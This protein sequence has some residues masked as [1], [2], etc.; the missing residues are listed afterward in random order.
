MDSDGPLG[1]GEVVAESAGATGPVGEHQTMAPLE[2]L[3]SVRYV[4][5]AHGEKT[6]VLV[7]LTTWE[8]LLASWQQLIEMLEDQED[9]AIVHDWLKKRAAGEA[10][11]VTLDELER[12]LI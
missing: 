2:M 3:P 9:K 11:T 8:A 12:E 5:D 7:P 4:T 1:K 6:D 10:Q